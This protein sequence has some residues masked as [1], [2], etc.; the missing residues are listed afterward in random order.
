MTGSHGWGNM[1]RFAI[2]VERRNASKIIRVPVGRARDGVRSQGYQSINHVLL[3]SHVRRS[4]WRAAIYT[5]HC[6]ACSLLSSMFL[7]LSFYPE[8][9]VLVKPSRVLDE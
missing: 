5:L 7:L 8:V 9:A 6:S 4:L 2:L 3:S 1:D